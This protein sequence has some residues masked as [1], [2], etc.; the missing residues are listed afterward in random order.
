MDLDQT[1]C[2]VRESGLQANIGLLL[3]TYSLPHYPDFDDLGSKGQTRGKLCT[4]M[5]LTKPAPGKEKAEM[6]FRRGVH[7]MHPA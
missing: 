5:D 7:L 4:F 1:L 2:E 6:V 3:L